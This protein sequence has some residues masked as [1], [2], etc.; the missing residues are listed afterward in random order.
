MNSFITRGGWW[1]VT[2]SVLILAV[3]AGGVV[4]RADERHVTS[5]V[6]GGSL[7]LLGAAFGIA[8]VKAA[9]KAG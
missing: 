7:N 8:G 1:V 4:F 9:E 6:L 2:E 5:L 3:L